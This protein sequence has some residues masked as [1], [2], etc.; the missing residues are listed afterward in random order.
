MEIYYFIGG[1]LAMGAFASGTMVINFGGNL[2]AW[3]SPQVITLF[4]VSGVLF[5]TFAIQQ[6]KSYF[7]SSRL[8]PVHFLKSRDLV[9]LFAEVAAGTSCM[10]FLSHLLP[11]IILRVRPA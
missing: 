8:F 1:I 11:A 6:A 2:Y 3:S 10:Y 5:T 9:I 7:T 4:I